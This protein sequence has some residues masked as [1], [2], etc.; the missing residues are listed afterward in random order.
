MQIN[1]EAVQQT[2]YTNVCWVY[3][4]D[5]NFNFKCDFMLRHI[6]YKKCLEPEMEY[7]VKNTETCKDVVCCQYV[8][9]EKEYANPFITVEYFVFSGRSS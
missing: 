5:H 2:V 4:S 7:M 8:F 1:L 3:T 6:I 9:V